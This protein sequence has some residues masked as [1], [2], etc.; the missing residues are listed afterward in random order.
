MEKQN[1]QHPENNRE[2]ELESEKLKEAHK[3]EHEA[4]E[5]LE[6]SHKIEE[7]LEKKADELKKEAQELEEEAHEHGH[8]HDDHDHK[9]EYKIYVNGREKIWK[10]HKISF[11]QVVDLYSGGSSPN[12]NTAYTITYAK[13]VKPKE[14]GSLVKGDVIIVKEG[15]EFYVT[16]TNKS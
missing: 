6:E 7:K 10:E 5:L 9:K 13:G 1:E 12:P 8:E 16:E 2:H 11:D 4:D 14:D 3:L 15:M